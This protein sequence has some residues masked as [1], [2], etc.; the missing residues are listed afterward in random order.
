MSER[1][2]DQRG[3]SLIE[4]LIATL[5]LLVAMAAVFAAVHPAQ[6]SFAA[7]PERADLQQR[8]RVVAET[9]SRELGA[10]GS[11]MSPGGIGS[12]ATDGLPPLLPYREGL[13]GA[14]PP[15]TFRSDTITLL[16]TT[17][18]AAQTTLAAGLAATS[19][20]ALID[21]GALCGGDASCRFRAGMDVVVFDG[22]GA[23]DAFLVTA[24]AG[25]AVSLRPNGSGGSHVY[26]PGSRIVETSRRTFYLKADAAAGAYQLMRYDGGSGDDVPVVDHI[27][28]FSLE[29]LGEPEPPRLL[30][31]LDSGGVLTSYG[32][33]PPDVTTPAAAYPP[34]ENCLFARDGGGVPVSR[35]TALPETRPGLAALNA[36]VLG[37]GPWCPDASAPH[38]YDADLLRV[39]A[40]VISVRVEAAAA[41]VR[42]SNG[43][44]FARAGSSRS[45]LWFV[46][47]QNLTFT[48]APPGLETRR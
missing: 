20:T 37:D 29:Y 43:R 16:S 32:P 40:V 36:G 39:R 13:R 27:V 15:G 2:S 1:P 46:P 45:G 33:A 9:L 17:R 7:E 23:Y 22:S 30:R 21:S 41:G 3:F 4:L 18:G 14:D 5:L 24:V 42:G 25:G 12:A 8:M 34:G 10:A 28:R 38:R 6:G 11:G 26:P 48:V 31:D 35:L 19:T 44:L 47:D